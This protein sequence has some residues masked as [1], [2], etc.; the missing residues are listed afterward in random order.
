M[1]AH[2]D[3]RSLVLDADKKKSIIERFKVHESDTGSTEL[4]V[5]L[6]TERINEITEHLKAHPH[7]FHSQRG[8]LKLIGHRRRLLSYLSR[9]DFKTYQALIDKLGLRK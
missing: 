3:L 4:Q 6:L 8:L 1:S 7:D 2:H 9:R 5:A